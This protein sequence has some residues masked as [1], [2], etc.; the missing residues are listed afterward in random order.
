MK[1]YCVNGHKLEDNIY[2]YARGRT[3][4][5]TC[6]GI[7]AKKYRI[8]HPW[9]SCFIAAKSRCQNKKSKNYYGYGGRGIRILI[10]LEEIKSLW[11]RDKAYNLKIPSIDRIDNDGNYELSNCRFIE[12]SENARKENLG[13]KS[14]WAK[15]TEKQ[16]K[17]IRLLYSRGGIFQKDIG[18]IYGVRRSTVSAIVCYRN[19]GHIK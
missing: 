13:E 10:T 16:V 11:F 9:I 12:Q 7:S 15:L 1:E 5:K 19:W 17:E 3:E 18:K 4:C 8:N 6:M 14:H 2:I